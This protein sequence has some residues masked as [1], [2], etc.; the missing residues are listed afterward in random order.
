ML[1]RWLNVFTLK[2]SFNPQKFIG[3]FLVLQQGNRGPGCG[4]VESK[5]VFKTKS[6]INSSDLLL[7]LTISLLSFWTFNVSGRPMEKVYDDLS[8]SFAILVGL[9]VPL[10]PA[11]LFLFWL[12]GFG[13]ALGLQRGAG[14]RARWGCGGSPRLWLSCLA[15]F[16]SNLL[17][18]VKRQSLCPSY[19]WANHISWP[20]CLSVPQHSAFLLDGNRGVAGG[21]DTRLTHSSPRSSFAWTTPSIR[22]Q[23][24]TWK[25]WSIW[26]EQKEV[27]G[28]FVCPGPSVGPL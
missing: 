23:I 11:T 14:S 22:A 25:S 20:G 9:L 24:H 27:E 4:Q 3:W 18:L 10:L 5:P 2:I 28:H 16:F 17:A 8:L 6:N 15:P 7:S 19:P 26:F 12:Q 1:D 13:L 21:K